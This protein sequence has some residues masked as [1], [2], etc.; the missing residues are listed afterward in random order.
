MRHL[1]RSL[2]AAD[3]E[4]IADIADR[5]RRLPIDNSVVAM[6]LH[7][8]ARDLE[9]LVERSMPPVE[10]SAQHGGKELA[11]ADDP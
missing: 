4:R 6:D 10:P 7:R 2:S 1:N 3:R 8:I 9:A 11:L 5:L